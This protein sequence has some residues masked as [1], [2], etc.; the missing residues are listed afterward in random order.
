MNW[1]DPEIHSNTIKP[2]TNY[3][4]NS[5]SLYDLRFKLCLHGNS[6]ITVVAVLLSVD[7]T[8]ATVHL[9]LYR[10]CFC[11]FLFLLRCYVKNLFLIKTQKRFERSNIFKPQNISLRAQLQSCFIAVIHFL[12]SEAKT[13]NISLYFEAH[14]I[15]GFNKLFSRV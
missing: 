4:Q 13:C 10:W 12:L 11:V 3:E 6:N 15:E 14:Y 7:Q 2:R 8:E 9:H 1:K 5:H